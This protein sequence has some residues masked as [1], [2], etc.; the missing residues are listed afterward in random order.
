MSENKNIERL[1][2]EKF[3]DFEVIPEEPVW[4]NIEAALDKKEKR[5]IIPF[6]WK[7]SGIAAALL[8]GFLITNALFFS[9]PIGKNNVV[10]QENNI[11]VKIQPNGKSDENSIKGIKEK[12]AIV[13]SETKL[14]TDKSSQNKVTEGDRKSTRLNSSHVL[15][16][17]M[18]SSA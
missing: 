12:E 11:S 14:S 17:R 6:W 5:R 2:Q 3:K 10:N 9:N 16:S 8:L 1:F 4:D 7:L 13:A 15:R 18:P